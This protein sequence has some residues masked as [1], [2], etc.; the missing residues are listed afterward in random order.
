MWRLIYAI[1]TWI[2]FELLNIPLMLLGWILVPL[3]AACGA[4]EKTDDNPTKPDDG[5]IYHFT[6]PFM[7]L[8]DNYGDGIANT[9]YWKAPNLFL[10]IIYWSCLRN[11]TN[12]LRIVPYLSCKINPLN[13]R[14]IG[15]FGNCTSF[16][17]WIRLFTPM[18][19]PSEE[20][21]SIAKYDT[22]VPQ[23]FF[24]WQGIYSNFYWQYMLNGNL[25][26]F[27]IGWKIFPTDIYGV[28]EYRKFGAGF[29]LQNK[30][31]K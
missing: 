22:K 11:P 19:D 20:Q 23:W 6:W 5:P 16:E 9:N 30:V 3:A 7:F 17:D 10:Q 12:N 28:T 31:V 14:F 13:V 26:R 4:Y 15:S 18:H 25:R 2:L 1:P 27:W 29:A 24:C 21:I 8:W